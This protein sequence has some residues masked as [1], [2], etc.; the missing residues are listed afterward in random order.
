MA[1]AILNPIALLIFMHAQK[2]L[3]HGSR[4]MM[5]DNGRKCYMTTVTLCICLTYIVHVYANDFLKC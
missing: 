2:C 5:E 4:Y 1:E 3:Q